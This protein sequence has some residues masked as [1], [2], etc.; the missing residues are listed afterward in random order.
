MRIFEWLGSLM[1]IIALI[2]FV[3]NPKKAISSIPEVLATNVH[4]D[5]HHLVL[6]KTEGTKAKRR[7]PQD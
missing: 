3:P 6:Q 7:F 1:M 4:M 2:E 5:K